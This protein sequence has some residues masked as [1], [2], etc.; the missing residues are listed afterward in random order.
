[1]KVLVVVGNRFVGYEL[2]WR[3]FAGGHEVTLFNS[4]RL[5]LARRLA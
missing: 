3:L 5:E 1:M 4:R 2:T